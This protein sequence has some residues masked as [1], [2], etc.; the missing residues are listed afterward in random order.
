MKG[1]ELQ[2]N[3]E[4][5]SPDLMLVQHNCMGF[6][7]THTG[8]DRSQKDTC[9]YEAPVITIVSSLYYFLHF[10]K[11][12]FFRAIRPSWQYKDGQK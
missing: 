7:H 2:G 10:N 4:I 8:G 6:V 5:T 12:Y 1:L 3:L 9:L 11:L